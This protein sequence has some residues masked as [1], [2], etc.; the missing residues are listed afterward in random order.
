MV[1]AILKGIIVFDEAGI[2]QASVGLENIKVNQELF[3]SFMSA[4]QIYA[5]RSIGSEMKGLTY[6][7]I[8]LMMGRAGENYVVTLHSVD[9]P[10][11]EWNH[12]ATL[13]VVEGDGFR[14]NNQYLEILRELLT[15]EKLSIDEAT[16]FTLIRR[17]S[18]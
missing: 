3:G 4:I 12:R 10:D 15:E 1:V 13:R 14:L 11:A 8:R 2:R 17:D 7:T 18:T 9:D 16:T 5:Q 6:S